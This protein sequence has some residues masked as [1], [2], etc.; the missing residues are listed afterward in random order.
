MIDIETHW[1]HF[2]LNNYLPRRNIKNSVDLGHVLCFT[3]IL[4]IYNKKF[5][6]T[7]T[8]MQHKCVG[9]CAFCAL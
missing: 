4:N 6:I 9:S 3:F 8:D 1:R 2:S 5:L 7:I